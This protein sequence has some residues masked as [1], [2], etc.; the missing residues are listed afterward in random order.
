MPETFKFP[1]KIESFQALR[2]FLAVSVFIS[3]FTIGEHSPISFSAVVNMFYLLS[4]FVIMLSTRNPSKVKQFF[5]RRLVRLLP[6]Y[7]L[8]TV[9]TFVAALVI[10]SVIGY[11]PTVLQ[12]IQS[13]LFIPYARGTA[14][15]TIRIRPIVGPGHTMMAEMAFTVVFFL[16]MLISHKRRGLIS[17]IS[18]A[19]LYVL[20]KFITF[21]N[22]FLYFYVNHCHSAWLF[23]F[24]GILIFLVFEK[25]EAKEIDIHRLKIACIPFALISLACFVFYFLTYLRYINLDLISYCSLLI[26]LLIYDAAGGKSFKPLV[27]FGDI[28][29][30]FYLVH[31]YVVAVFE[32]LFDIYTVNVRNILLMI[33]TLA[34]SIFAAYICNFIVEKK[35]SSFLNK[36]LFK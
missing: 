33:L 24:F 2:A 27:V 32:K 6:V 21:N 20:G 7:Y 34:V 1:K 18:C 36:K 26:F 35:F 5:P 28:S 16:C 19:V 3:H 29:F 9:A 14:N 25:I 13:L 10:P 12:L 23:F 30:S 8:L 15:G 4:G 22:V 11:E 31:Y 17:M